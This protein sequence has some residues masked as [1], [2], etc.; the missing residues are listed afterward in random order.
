MGT[1]DLIPV[2]MHS[3]VGLEGKQWPQEEESMT[4][5]GKIMMSQINFYFEFRLLK[6]KGISSPAS[7][8]Q[9]AAFLSFC[10]FSGKSFS[11]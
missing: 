1:P 3:K 8:S 2:V 4:K 5:F 11:F 10:I 9:P 6:L 7:F